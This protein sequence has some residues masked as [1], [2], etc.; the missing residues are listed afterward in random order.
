MNGDVV[1]IDN[2]EIS[3]ENEQN[4]LELVRKARIDLPPSA[5]IRS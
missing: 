2:K 1:Y 3:I 5:T 4:L